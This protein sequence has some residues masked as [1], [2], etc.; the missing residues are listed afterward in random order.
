MIWDFMTHNHITLR[1]VGTE[2]FMTEMPQEYFDLPFTVVPTVSGKDANPVILL[3]QIQE[4]TQLLG[5]FPEL[6]SMIRGGELLQLLIDTIHP[7]LTDR[8]VVDPTEAGPAGQPPIEQV[9][10]QLL[11]VVMGPEG[12]GQ[13]GLIAQVGHNTEFLAE[14]AADEVEA[15]KPATE[16]AS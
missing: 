6:K 5:T 9:L 4:I 10:N 13:S 12:D 2:S 11:G 7:A 14:I 16:P 3:A 15:P 8:I 1:S